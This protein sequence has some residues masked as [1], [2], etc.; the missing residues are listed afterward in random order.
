MTRSTESVPQPPS[1]GS[2][3]AERRASPRFP[4]NLETFCQPGSGKLDD[5]WWRVRVRDISVQGLS[6]VVGKR[7]EPGIGLLVELPS[8]RKS[9]A[10]LQARVV[11]ST[12]QAD[13]RYVTGCRFAWA[14]SEEEMRVCL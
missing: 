1:V 9:Y 8:V 6:L 7:F 12:L 3:G 10:A 11:H 14:L 13:G 5:F 2:V 4:C